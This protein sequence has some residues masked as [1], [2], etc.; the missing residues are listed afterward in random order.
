VEQS[1]KFLKAFGKNLAYLR[2]Q[3]EMTQETLAFECELDVMTISR[4]E[5]GILNISITN[6]LKLSQAL[7]VHHKRLLEFDI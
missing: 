7:N 1:D 4:M 2:K 5:R 3:R 6:I